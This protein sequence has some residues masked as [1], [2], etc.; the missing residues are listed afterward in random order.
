MPT[1]READVTESYLIR[2]EGDPE[3]MVD[4]D[5]C[6][7]IEGHYRVKATLLIA[8]NVAVDAAVLA[9]AQGMLSEASQDVG[10]DDLDP[11]P[12]RMYLS[13]ARR[14]W[15]LAERAL[16]AESEAV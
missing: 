4:V 11:G 1:E 6:D 3:Q 9:I 16:D 12:Q 15:R 7:V 5:I 2:I 13:R 14:L 10:W 8:S